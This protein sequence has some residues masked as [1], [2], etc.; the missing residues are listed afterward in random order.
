MTISQPQFL[1]R[2]GGRIA[3]DVRGTGPTVVLVPGMGDL[4]STWRFVVGPLAGAGF[5]VVATDLR[6]HG[7]SDAT[8]SEYG[9]EQTAA[10]VVALIEHVGGPAVIVGTSMGASVGTLVA[11]RRPELVSGLALLAPF[12]RDPARSAAMTVLLRLAT[13]PPWAAPAWKAYLPSLYRGRKPAD[14]SEQ[15]T[16]VTSGIARR[17][18]RSAFSRTTRTS[19]SGA[20]RMLPA[21]STPTLVLM[22]AL[23]PDFADPAAEASWIA[24]ALGGRAVMVPDAGHYPQAQRP[25]IVVPELTAFLSAATARA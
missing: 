22:G 3:F 14:F 21:V 4:R 17:G 6:G 12:V 9:D 15:L 11:A 2:P 10:D 16:A 7:D 5:R 23:D 19:H 1:S 25:D 24:T 18:Y 13:A 8:F 20:E